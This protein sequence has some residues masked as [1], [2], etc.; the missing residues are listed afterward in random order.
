MDLHP[1]EGVYSPLSPCTQWH[2]KGVY[3]IPYRCLYSRNIR[4]LFLA[5]RIIS[6]SHVAFGSTRVMATCGHTAQAV[7]IAAVICARDGLQPADLVRTGRIAELQRELLSA[8]QFI[9]G[10]GLKDSADLA[11]TAR[12]TASSSFMLD[13][14]APSG[15][16]QPLDAS[17]AMLLP[18]AAGR[19]P[20]VTF[21]ACAQAAVTLEAE[22]RVSG[23]PGNFTPDVTL[24]RQSIALHAGAQEVR[25]DFGISLV[26]PQYAFF[27]LLRNPGVDVQLSEQRVTGVLS[28]SQS[29]NRA[30]AKGAKQEPPPGIGIDSFEF[31]LPARRPAGQNLALRIDPPLDLFGAENVRNGI[32]RPTVQPNAWVAALDDP[33]PRLTACWPT[34]QT[35]GRIE[36][37][38]DT[39]FDHPMES[40]LM[41]H[42]EREIPFCVKKYRILDDQENVRFECLDNHQTRNSIRLEPQLL[43]RALHV[44][45]LE[46][47][48]A[49]AAI[50]EARFYET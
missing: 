50:F 4:N 11:Q 21:F 41:G 14:L 19:V 44:E 23:R 24:A 31:W 22:F 46:T 47:H 1:A 15:K 38:F 9:P 18:L 42:P 10:M 25:L 28:L 33:A 49:P 34:P 13:Q 12:L 30:V 36:L 7:G 43:T 16:H 26:V 39:D 48:G 8:G 27:C 40:V 3:Q 20:A 45:V 37:S 2:S 32:A 35:I 6:A 5:G 29:M 17:R